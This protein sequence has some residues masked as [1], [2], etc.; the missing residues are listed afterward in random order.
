[1]TDAPAAPGDDGRVARLL[2]R[3]HPP[4]ALPL[5]RPFTAGL[6]PLLTGMGG[7]V[8][9]VL[10]SRRARWVVGLV[11]DRYTITVAPEG[12][13]ARGLIRTRQVA[14]ADAEAVEL[15]SLTVLL[16]RR[17][18]AGTASTVAGRVVRVPG[19]RWLLRRAI[20]ALGDVIAG[21]AGRATADDVPQTLVA[22][23]SR[24][25]RGIELGGPLALTSALSRGLTLA[26]LDRA[27]ASAVPVEGAPP[28]ASQR[29]PEA[30][31][32]EEGAGG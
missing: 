28:S 23:R 18:V 12:I 16:A 5:D 27:G 1:M 29:R 22:V 8:G 2:E 32:S 15:E 24:R 10:R 11:G 3:I 26:A 31:R 25:G 17:V 19:L 14:W 6:G 13:S 7:V 21:A 20:E 30:Q 9:G 4:P